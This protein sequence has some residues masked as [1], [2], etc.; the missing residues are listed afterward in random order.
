[1]L[2]G[3]DL[4]KLDP[5]AVSVFVAAN[6]KEISTGFQIWLTNFDGRWPT[7]EALRSGNLFFA[8]GLYAECIKQH[9]FRHSVRGFYP[10]AFGWVWDLFV[11]KIEKNYKSE[12]YELAT[13]LCNMVDSST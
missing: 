6:K 5:F 3:K 2:T 10:D 1:M 7:D 12:Y 9:N 4:Y 11:E 8:R 13:E